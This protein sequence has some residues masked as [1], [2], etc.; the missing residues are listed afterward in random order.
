MR[1]A[2]GTPIRSHPSGAP[3]ARV[4]GSVFRYPFPSNLVPQTFFVKLPA[5]NLFGQ[6][7]QDVATVAAFTY[8]TTGAGTDPLATPL[9]GALAAGTSQDWGTVGTGVTAAAD[10][11]RIAVATGLSI[12]LGALP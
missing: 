4:N 9:L 10:L 1:G 2:Y 11:T 8:T 7:L 12:D 6:A 3:F 5:F